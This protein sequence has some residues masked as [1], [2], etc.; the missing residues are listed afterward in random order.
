MALAQAIDAALLTAAKAKEAETL[1]VLRMVKAALQNE[2]INVLGAQGGEL[3]EEQATKVLRSE[4]KKRKDSIESYTQGGRP[5]LADK[6]QREVALI[7]SFLPAQLTEDQVRAKVDEV[8]AAITDRSNAGKVMGQI[9]GA[10]KGQPDDGALVK[11][12]VEE[13]LK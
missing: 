12:I 4:I 8:L 13:K 6:E 3:T 10:L 5:E 9:M 2:R 1:S 11:K 7:E